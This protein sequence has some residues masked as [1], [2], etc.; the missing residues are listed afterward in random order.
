MPTD[1]KP[2]KSPVVTGFEALQKISAEAAERNKKARA[3]R[4]EPE[5][6]TAPPIETDSM[7]GLLGSLKN[8][9]KY[10]IWGP[11]KKKEK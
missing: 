6:D 4:N 8:R 2:S 7:M 10:A 9:A 11:E 1:K 3:K 5:P